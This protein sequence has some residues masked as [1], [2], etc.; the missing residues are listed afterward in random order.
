MKR[1]LLHC[2]NCGNDNVLPPRLVR[3]HWRFEC[4]DCGQITLITP[5][6]DELDGEAYDKLARQW[7]K[8]YGLKLEEV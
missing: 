5:T 7:G 3:N 8:V 4:P 6:P 1:K 2:F